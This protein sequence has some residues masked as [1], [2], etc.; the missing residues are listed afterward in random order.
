MSEQKEASMNRNTIKTAKRLLGY[1]TS[2]LQG[3]V[4]LG[5]DLYF[6]QFHRDDLSLLVAEISV[7]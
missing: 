1:V 5:F 3:S 2:T 7:G 4:C 6:S